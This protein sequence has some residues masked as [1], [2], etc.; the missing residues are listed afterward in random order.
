M[1]V[2]LSMNTAVDR[3]MLVPNFADGEVFRAERSVAV[4][5]GKALNVARVLRQLGEPVRVVGTLGG[6]PENFV[7]TWCDRAGVDGRWVRIEAD[8]RTCVIVVDPTIRAPD[9]TERA[10]STTRRGRNSAG[11]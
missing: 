7:R 6:M 10:R 4:P 8:S 1:I 11:R 2:V 5:G 3:L 9:R